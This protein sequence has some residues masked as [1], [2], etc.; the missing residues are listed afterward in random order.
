M[1]D[2]FSTKTTAYLLA[3]L[4]ACSACL[5]TAAAQAAARVRLELFGEAQQVGIAMQDWAQA[6]DRAGISGVRISSLTSSVRIG[7]TDE[8]TPQQP[9][10]VV[11]G[12]LSSQDELTLPG[13]KYRRS[14]LKK[15]KVWLDDLAANGPE[16]RRPQKTVF[17]L[18]VEQFDDLRDDLSQTT[19]FSTVKLPCRE[20]AEK[21]AGQLRHPLHLGE[22]L[23]GADGDAKLG[24]ELS[25]IPFGT[26]LAYVLHSAGY[27]LVP[28]A[29]NK[30]VELAAAKAKDAPVEYWL[31]GRPTEKPLGE[32]LPGMVEFRNVNVENATVPQVL[33]A[34]GEKIKA[35]ILYD[36][37]AMAKNGVD[38]GAAKLNFPRERTTYGTALRKMLFKVGLKY[39]VRLDEADRPFLWIT[40]L[41]RT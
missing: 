13:G 21:I 7:V 36:Y 35:P 25:S 20:I 8:G 4:L 3:T 2:R 6:L 30:R 12:V 33:K 24:D 1:R 14:D 38:L 31:I 23:K 19:A 28:F 26:S 27:R 5:T 18:T 22:A 11:T 16:N 37:P 29:S 17:G 39:E 15:L 10:Y 9:A 34:I 41:K 32:I 40:T